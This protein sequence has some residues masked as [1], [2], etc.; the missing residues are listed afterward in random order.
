MKELKKK[1]ANLKK[2]EMLKKAQEAKLKEQAAAGGP[3]EDN[4][5]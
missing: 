1:K 5:E 3:N 4:K 2:A